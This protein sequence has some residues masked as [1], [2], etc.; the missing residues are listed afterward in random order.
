MKTLMLKWMMNFE[1]DLTSGEYEWEMDSGSVIES[2]GHRQVCLIREGNSNSPE[3]VSK[4]T[5]GSLNITLYALYLDFV[6]IAA[7]R[8]YYHIQLK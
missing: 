6:V 4:L 7:F 5:Y 2:D 1:C 8:E 3:T